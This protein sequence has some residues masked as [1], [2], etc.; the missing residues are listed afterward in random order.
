MK[1]LEKILNYFTTRQAELGLTDY[2]LARKAG[3]SPQAISGYKS[4]KYGMRLDTLLAL[5]GALRLNFFLVPRGDELRL[6]EGT[7]DAGQA[8]EPEGNYIAAA[9]MAL[10]V[11]RQFIREELNARGWSLYR[12]AK[13]AGLNRTDVKNF[14]DGGNISVRNFMRIL[15]A[16]DMGLALI[17]KESAGLPPGA[18]RIFFN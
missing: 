12:L 2:A 8:P 10:P 13:N 4:G 17:P 5:A 14:L 9:R 18:S 6:P 16:M 1:T 11:I 3:I 15:A 7:G